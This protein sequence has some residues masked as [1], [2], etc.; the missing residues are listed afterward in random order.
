MNESQVP[1]SGRRACPCTSCERLALAF[2]APGG[3][4]HAKTSTLLHWSATTRSAA[5][6]NART[7]RRERLDVS[8]DAGPI[9]GLARLG[10]LG[11]TLAVDAVAGERHGVETRARDPGLAGLAATEV[12]VLEP[13]QG[14]VDLA[15]RGFV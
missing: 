7:I 9:R 15:Q 14:V 2:P 10:P 1:A 3:P 13:V 8:P 5:A 11:P 4:S 6:R 12:P